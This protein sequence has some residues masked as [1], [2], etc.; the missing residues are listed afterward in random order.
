MERFSSL[1]EAAVG[2]RRVLERRRDTGQTNRQVRR[3]AHMAYSDGRGYGVIAEAG[4][5][6]TLLVG[7]VAIR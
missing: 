7:T 5:Y 3:S 2:R 4:G 1:E 6:W